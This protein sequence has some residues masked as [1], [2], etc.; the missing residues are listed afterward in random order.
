EKRKIE[1]AKVWF[2]MPGEYSVYNALCAV[3]VC[4]SYGLDFKKCAK[5][6]YSFK[7]VKG[8]CQYIKT[9]KGFK[10]IIDFAHTPQGL[11]KMLWAVKKGAKG[12]IILVFG[13]GGDR[14]KTKRPQMG[15]AAAK[16]ADYIFLTSDNPRTEDPYSIISDV[17]A[18]L[19]NHT[20][21]Y[22]VYVDRKIA[23]EN[24]LRKAKK[25]DIVILAGKGHEDYQ[26]IGTKINNFDEEKI[27]KEIL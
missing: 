8:R 16:G 11:E 20:V 7:G 24:A 26:I 15:L 23:I 18:E 27:V 14:D 5:S 25:D 9:G 10:V 12:R 17:E 3:A 4:V 2:N 1:K 22:E 21:P 6:L 13:C 19:K